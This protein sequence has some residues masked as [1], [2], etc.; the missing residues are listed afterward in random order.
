MRGLDL[1]ITENTLTQFSNY[2]NYQHQI[3]SSISDL[4]N[5]LPQ[6][7]TTMTQTG[8]A[9][10]ALDMYGALMRMFTVPEEE[11]IDRPYLNATAAEAPAA[12]LGDVTSGLPGSTA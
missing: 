10:Q 7:F 4:M 1:P 9:V 12:V 2:Q 6:A 8:N 11:V 5:G 3:I